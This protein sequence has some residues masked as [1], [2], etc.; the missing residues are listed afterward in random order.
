[1]NYALAADIIGM[2]QMIHHGC[3]L[4]HSAAASISARSSSLWYVMCAEE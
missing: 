4:I 2:L 3:I 1:M